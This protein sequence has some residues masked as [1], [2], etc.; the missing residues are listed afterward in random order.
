[1]KLQISSINT[2]PFSTQFVHSLALVDYTLRESTKEAYAVRLIFV[3]LALCLSVKYLTYLSLAQYSTLWKL[4]LMG[5]YE[6]RSQNFFTVGAQL[7]TTL[8]HLHNCTSISRVAFCGRT[9]ARDNVVSGAFADQEMSVL[10][11]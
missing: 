4:I 7:Q 10:V 2:F 5:S 1:M 11:S 3:C 6:W 9:R 8:S